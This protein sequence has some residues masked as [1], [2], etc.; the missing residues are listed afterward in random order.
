MFKGGWGVK[1]HQNRTAIVSEAEKM[2][3]ENHLHQ[4][5]YDQQLMAKHYQ[6]MAVESMVRV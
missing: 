1:I 2:F 5:G 6:S 3:R 4:Y